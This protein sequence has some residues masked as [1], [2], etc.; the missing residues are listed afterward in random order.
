MKRLMRLSAGTVF[1]G[2][3]VAVA[4]LAVAPAALAKPEKVQ[5]CHKTGSA[6]NPFVM[7]EIS[8]NAVDAHVAHGDVVPA[9]AGGCVAAGGVTPGDTPDTGGGNEGATGTEGA[10]AGTTG[11]QLGA[12]AGSV[13]PSGELPFTGFPVRV[14]LIAAAGFVASGLVLLC[15]S[16]RSREA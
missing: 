11:G 3:I 5:I 1:A 6:V 16:R 10:D 13:T 12:V 9:P 4:V 7:I 8:V 14:L 15:S 2:I